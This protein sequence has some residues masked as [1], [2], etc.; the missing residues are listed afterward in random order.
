MSTPIV[1]RWNGEAMEPLARFHNVANAEFVIGET[2][3]LV[4][5]HERSSASHNHF[6]ASLGDAWANLGED[7]AE[8]FPTSE[9]LR[10]WAL[11]RAG[12]RDERTFVAASKAEA[13]RL[14]AFVKPMDDYAVVVVRDAVVTVW[15]A[16]SQSMKAMGRKAFQESKDAVLQIVAGMI[17]ATPEQLGKAA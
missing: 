3:P 9:H 7:A 6:F 4:E 11:I 8:R 10:K 5:Q 15:T 12:Y 13:L 1:Y 16:K 2:Y 14:A 17:G